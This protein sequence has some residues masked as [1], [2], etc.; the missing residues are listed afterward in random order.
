MK[1]SHKCFGIWSLILLLA[2]GLVL[3]GCSGKSEGAEGGGSPEPKAV[4]EENNA[5][6]ET[7]KITELMQRY[8]D[9]GLK[10]RGKDT[11]EHLSAEMLTY[12][13]DAP[14]GMEAAIYKVNVKTGTVV[15]GVSGMPL[16]NLFLDANSVPNL[17]DMSGQEA[18][19]A[20]EDM[21]LPVLKEKG[22]VYE[23]KM[24]EVFSGFVGDGFLE[25]AIPGSEEDTGTTFH[26]EVEPFTKELKT[27]PST[28]IGEID[29]DLGDGVAVGDKTSGTEEIPQLANLSDWNERG[30]NQDQEQSFDMDTA[31]WGKVR[32]VS[33][34]YLKGDEKKPLFLLADDQDRV[35]YTL[36]DSHPQNLRFQDILAIG[37]KDMNGDGLK[38]IVIINEYTEPNKK[39]GQKA[40]SRA[41][42]YFAQ[43][44]VY[45]TLPWY[46]DVLSDSVKNLTIANLEKK[47]A[48]ILQRIQSDLKKEDAQAA[49]DTL[50]GYICTPQLQRYLDWDYAASSDSVVLF[51]NES[52]TFSESYIV[53]AIAERL[54][55]AR[56][57]ELASDAKLAGRVKQYEKLVREM[58]NDLATYNYIASGGGTIWQIINAGSELDLQ[59]ALN[60]YADGNA[61]SSTV[62]VKA[63]ESLQEDWDGF[64]SELKSVIENKKMGAE[65][66]DALE[67]S[68]EDV[69]EL[70]DIEKALAKNMDQFVKLASKDPD[71]SVFI[72]HIEDSLGFEW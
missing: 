65:N 22:Y 7:G 57:A 35:L 19:Q 34:Y 55:E 30:F 39:S 68:P 31:S 49:L 46:N 44:K 38:D 53:Y 11:S 69:E 3:S 9:K 56:S 18:N 64:H 27:L 52:N 40:L 29:E 20:L 41:S 58:T 48:E 33:G 47:G 6:A 36:P 15:D 66:P 45:S 21:I 59:F 37:F 51:I 12:Y 4:T 24:D 2:G 5:D 62:D 17:K 63:L 67:L 71:A 16:Y 43:E 72:E 70:K 60:Q 14:E 10:Y 26:L 13:G 28:S 1:K 25:L 42:V 50:S 61:K 54:G 8:F 32:L 23:G